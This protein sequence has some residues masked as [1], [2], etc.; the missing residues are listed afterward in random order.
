LIGHLLPNAEGVLDDEVRITG[1]Q[2]CP[3]QA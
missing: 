3:K 1:F 2:Q